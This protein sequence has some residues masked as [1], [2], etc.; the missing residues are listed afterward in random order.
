MKVLMVKIRESGSYGKGCIE[1]KNEVSLGDFKQLSIIFSD[2]QNYGAKIE[3]AFED[4][5]KNKAE[6]FPF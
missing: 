2:L 4:F 3:K 5:K 6:G 1:Y